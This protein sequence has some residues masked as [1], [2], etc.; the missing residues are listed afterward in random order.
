MNGFWNW[1]MG[2]KLS[3]L[4]GADWRLGFRSDY[5]DYARVGLIVAAVALGWLVVRC[6]RREGSAP[7]GIKLLLAAVRMATILLVLGML[8]RP[9]VILRFTRTLYSSVVVVLDDSKSMSFSD[10]YAADPNRRENL[11]RAV[12]VEPAR[13]GERTRNDLM[14]AVLADPN[15]PLVTLAR[16]HPLVLMGFSTTR[17]GQEAYTRLLGEVDQ[18]LP[19]GQPA[20]G[21]YRQAVASRL[22]E[23][24]G[25]L[26]SAGYE[27]DVPAALSSA[28]ERNRG[29]RVAAAVLVSDGQ[30]TAR[31]AAGRLSGVLDYADQVG[32]S[33]FGV[34]VGDT[35]EPRNV[36]V[37]GLRAPREVRRGEQAEVS[38][39]VAHRNLDGEKVTVRIEA[40][41]ADQSQWTDT[42]VSTEV[43]LVSADPDET[44]RDRGAV[45]VTVMVEPAELGE[46]TY[47]AVIAPRDDE[48]NVDD[49]AA[50]AL[51]TVTDEKVRVLLISGDA[52]WEFQYLRNMLLRQPDAYRMSVWQQNADAEINQAASTGMRLSRLPQELVE[53]IG[54]PGG[55]PHPGYDVVILYDPQPTRDGFDT[56]FV[57][58]LKR[59]VQFHGGGVCYIAGNKYT[60]M[61]CRDRQ[62]FKPLLDLLPV[63]VAPNT[64]S[65]TGSIMGRSA[66]AWPVRPTRYGID[67][68]VLRLAGSTEESRQV[69]QLLPGIYWSHPVADIKPAA[70]VLAVTSDAARR[71]EKGRPQP[72]VALQPVGSGRVV[73]VGFD[74]TWRWRFLQQGA[75]HRRF[76]S[77]VIRYLATLKARQVVIATGGDRFSAGERITIEVEAYDENF[78]PLETDEFEVVM[79]DTAT[80]ERVDVPPL[81]PV[82]NRPG[83]YRTQILADQTGTFELSALPDDPQAEEKVAGKRIVIELPKAEAARSEADARKMQA[84]ASRPQQFLHLHEA[85]QLAQQIPTGRMTAVRDVYRELWDTNLALLAVVV[86]LGAEWIVRKRYNMT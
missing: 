75:Y 45:D 3:G 38:A 18:V 17:P 29:R 27:T 55:D 81:T 43:T 4:A 86:L 77:N 46:Y 1:L 80:G 30:D 40:R 82:E 5:S 50:E 22:E 59:F 35:A 56:D 52:G 83:Q 7:R 73:F 23:L 34:L 11:A 33:R 61:V 84:V 78:K 24:L 62:L 8:L 13:L 28:L 51:V 85:D 76:W 79:T 6:Y 69:W 20:D 19:P 64:V 67:H 14:R 71:T 48:D 2:D 63:F 54:S 12:G 47:R 42:G 68:P 32:F 74:G 58:M 53:L 70:R 9:A 39:L 10:R 72:L 16:D 26:S 65:I 21:A 36:A 31:D 44:D 41:K 60:E 37:V 66:S 25:G 57:D 49:N 15:G